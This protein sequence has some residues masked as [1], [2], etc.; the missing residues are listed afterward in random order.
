MASRGKVSRRANDDFDDEGDSPQGYQSKAP[1]KGRHSIRSPVRRN[2]TD[3]EEADEEIPRGGRSGR[4]GARGGGLSYDSEGEADP[5]GGGRDAGKSGPGSRRPYESDHEERPSRSGTSRALVV[6]KSNRFEDDDHDDAG[7]AGPSRALVPRAKGNRHARD[8]DDDDTDTIVVSRYEP[9]IP[10]GIPP[11]LFR[12]LM[13]VF[14]VPPVRV[15]A[16]C[17]RGKI[18]WDVGEKRPSFHKLL[19]TFPDKKAAWEDWCDAE[20]FIQQR[21]YEVQ[22]ERHAIIEDARERRMEARERR[23]EARAEVLARLREMRL[24][25]EERSA[26]LDEGRE[27][28]R[29]GW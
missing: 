5:R 14:Q 3:D 27:M 9:I 12:G 21:H 22:M 4:S 20:G 29:Y 17:A 15:E 25:N 13:E 28:R 6:R 24:E 7:R 16:W 23:M 11:Y 10:E 18:L 26:W 2:H 19:A 8:D 1:N